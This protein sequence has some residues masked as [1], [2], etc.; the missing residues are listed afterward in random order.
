MLKSVLAASALSLISLA[1]VA[2]E[3]LQLEEVASFTET[4][5]GNITVTPNGR[6]IVSMQPLDGPALKVV[7][8]LKDGSKAPFPTQDWADGP[9]AGELGL[10]AV[11]GIDTD[12]NG[13]VWML[14]M[15]SEASAPRLL[16]W[17]SE[18]NSLHADLQIDK[19]ALAANS[20]LQD[21]AI[22][23]KRGQIYIADMTLGNLAGPSKPAIV[24][25]DLKTGEA[26]RLLEA[27]EQFIS[28]D[29]DVVID[30]GLMAAK[31]ED[32]SLNKLR[33]GLNPIAISDDSEWV[34]FGAVNG[35]QIF[36]IPAAKLADAS[37]KSEELAASIEEYGPKKPS[38]GMTFNPNGGLIVS[39]IENSAI[40]LTTEGKYEVLIQ[41]E[42]L[43][44]PD[45]FD[46][47]KDG[48]VY[49]TQ[50]QLHKHP[51]FNQGVNG[52]KAPFYVM[53]FPIPGK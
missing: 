21:F 33:F 43:S 44:W 41:D 14:D 24:V 22:D 53:R 35:E 51:A 2:G 26:R 50:N 13:V 23:E 5:P 4:R 46:V 18:T 31:G 32:G 27:A 39:D 19:S 25:V 1:A 16:G 36:R 17:N 52:A 9:E 40:G 29:R 11:I 3:L 15:G 49:V 7:E 6:M 47:A 45:G 30:G 34:Y 28:P 37:A 38:D 20:F 8:V 42:R 48:Y 10:S 12:S